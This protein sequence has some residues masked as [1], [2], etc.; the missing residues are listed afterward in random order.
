[1][2]VKHG[3]RGNSDGADILRGVA[4]LLVVGYHLANITMPWSGWTRNFGT[5]S[6]V[7]LLA[8]YL[9]SLGWVGVPLFFVL[10]GF[11]IELSTLR[12]GNLKRASFFWRR[13][14]RIYPTY[15]V[16]LM[17]FTMVARVDVSSP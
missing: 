14:W 10:S 9:L 5:A 3:P 2:M 11:C 15:L 1:M 8:S 12:A 13:F 16:S 6:G 17:I 7:G 4:I